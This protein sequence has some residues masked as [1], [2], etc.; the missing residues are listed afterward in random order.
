MCTKIFLISFTYII[1]TITIV[2]SIPFIINTI[3]IVTSI[4][5]F[6]YN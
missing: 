1:N 5:F 2:T 6:Y 4:P 3:T